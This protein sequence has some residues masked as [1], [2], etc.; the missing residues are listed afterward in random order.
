MKSYREVDFDQYPKNRINVK[1][2][3]D[4]TNPI[5]E[6][7][8]SEME[9]EKVVIE[10]P[11]D[12]KKLHILVLP[13][14]RF[15]RNYETIILP[16]KNIHLRKLLTIIHDFYHKHSMSI[17][18]LYSLN[19][20]DVHNYIYDAIQHKKEDVEKNKIYPIDIMGDK[21][22]FEGIM[23]EEN[24]IGDVQYTLNLGS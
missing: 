8:I 23:F 18:E 12:K 3:W 6:I 17:Q 11:K 10:K 22:H 24:E 15:S 21:T 19:E 16:N 20:V 7:E 2:N 4:I 14:H 1:I 9:M 13:K 5:E